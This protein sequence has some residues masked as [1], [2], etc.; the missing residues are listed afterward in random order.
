MKAVGLR[1]ILLITYNGGVESIIY[2]N[3]MASLLS[4]SSRGEGQTNSVNTG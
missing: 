3:R 2:A 1:E 4:F